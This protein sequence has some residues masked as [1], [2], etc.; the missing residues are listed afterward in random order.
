V[1][2]TPPRF[3]D[4]REAG[5]ELARLLRAYAGQPDLLV[6]GLPRGGVPVAYEIALALDAPLDVFLVRKLGV[7]GHEELAMGAIAGGGTI[8]LN[9]SVVAEL[10]IPENTIQAVAAQEAQELARRDRAYRDGRPPPPILGQTVILVDDGL[11][12]GATMRAAVQAVYRQGPR[13]VVIAVPV[14]APVT[15][16]EF[17]R[18]VDAIICARTP[19]P[20][21]AVGLW[22]DDFN[23]TSD[24]EVR[25]L[26]AAAAA[27]PPNG[28][29]HA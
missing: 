26:L 13:R 21:H 16:E 8:V 12:T 1:S 29:P 9:D 3:Q 24:D 23:P 28:P 19:V 18:E 6:L 25:G 5:R 17:A 15:C 10:G 2:I 20:F 7:P 27:R 4:R 14:A 22:Y 11:A